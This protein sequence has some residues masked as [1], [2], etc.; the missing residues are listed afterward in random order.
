[1]LCSAEEGA[2][3]AVRLESDGL[4][5]ADCGVRGGASIESVFCPVEELLR[6]ALLL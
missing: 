1:M 3:E 4:A 5:V 6:G 2:S